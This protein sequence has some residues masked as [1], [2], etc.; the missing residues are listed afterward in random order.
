MRRWSKLHSF[1]H[2]CLSSS[3]LCGNSEIQRMIFKTGSN[4]LSLYSRDF[5]LMP[6]IEIEERKETA[7]EEERHAKTPR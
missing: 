5:S 6:V 3:F 1:A 2:T 7:N 4:I